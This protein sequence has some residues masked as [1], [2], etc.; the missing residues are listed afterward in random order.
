MLSIYTLLFSNLNKIR[1]ESSMNTS[2]HTR[3]LCAIFS[4]TNS[5]PSSIHH[6]RLSSRGDLPQKR[7][8]CKSRKSNDLKL[9][10]S[11]RIQWPCIVCPIEVINESFTHFAH[12]IRSLFFPRKSLE[13]TP[14]P[15]AVRRQESAVSFDN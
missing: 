1:G 8:F 10:D 4:F 7:P 12:A 15:D 13:R 9:I 2:K 5:K 6:D 14:P 3:H 11:Q